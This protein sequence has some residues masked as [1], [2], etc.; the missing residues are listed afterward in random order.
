MP[1]NST[2]CVDLTNADLERTLR[3][4]KVEAEDRDLQLALQASVADAAGGSGSSSG[5]TGANFTGA[6]SSRLEST[7]Q[8]IKAAI[9]ESLLSFSSHA[10]QDLN[11]RKR[12][13]DR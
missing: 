5:A 12:L 8:Q 9:A 11:S 10:N 6:V 2:D 1:A 3:E 13:A 4:S 7:E